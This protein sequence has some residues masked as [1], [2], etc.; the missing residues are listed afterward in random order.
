MYERPE[1]CYIVLQ[2][3]PIALSL[4]HRTLVPHENELPDQKKKPEKM[5]FTTQWL[6]K[7]NFVAVRREV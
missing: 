5:T 6:E 3:R 4:V 2:N 1:L 7:Y